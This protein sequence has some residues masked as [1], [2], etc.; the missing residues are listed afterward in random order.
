MRRTRN[1]SGRIRSSNREQDTSNGTHAPH[2]ARATMVMRLDGALILLSIALSAFLELTFQ[3][4]KRER[5]LIARCGGSGRD[6]AQSP[7]WIGTVLLRRRI[8]GRKLK[9]EDA[10][11]GDEAREVREYLADRRA[12]FAAGD[13]GMHAT[14]NT[15]GD[16]FRLMISRWGFLGDP[17]V[18]QG[19]FVALTRT[20]FRAVVFITGRWD[21]RYGEIDVAFATLPT[22]VSTSDLGLGWRRF[23]GHTCWCQNYARRLAQ[24]CIA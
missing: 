8:D 1:L 10:I 3:A 19:R 14:T 22:M 7:S 24:G 16:A 12:L 17:I 23:R 2:H 4:V 15:T 11:D 13:A 9:A 21:V 18:C 5:R 20:A 6:G